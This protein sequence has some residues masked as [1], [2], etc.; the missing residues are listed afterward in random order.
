MKA[1]TGPR[2]DGSTAIAYPETMMAPPRPPSAEPDKPKAR[3]WGAVGA[4]ARVLPVGWSL[5]LGVVL[6]VAHFA[7]HSTLLVRRFGVV[8]NAVLLA[9][10]I[11][12]ELRREPW[13]LQF[14]KRM[15][16]PERWSSRAFVE[17]NRFLSRIWALIF[18]LSLLMAAFGRSA[19]VLFVLPNVLLGVA[20]ALGPSLARWYG[21]RLTQ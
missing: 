14:A 15:A 16:P 10:V 2:L 19:F 5:G 9:Q 11:R 18:V 20:L 4:V 1:P 6:L 7:F 17:G 13:T 3:A 12:G 21:R 8:I